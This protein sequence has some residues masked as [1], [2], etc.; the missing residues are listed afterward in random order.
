MPPHLDGR[1]SALGLGSQ[2]L[3][4]SLLAWPGP[5]R[6]R[7]CPLFPR[8]LPPDQPLPRPASSAPQ[9]SASPRGLGPRE[10]RCK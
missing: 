4:P 7:C 3:V 2:D 1:P 10:T 5:L 9:Q 6:T 8:P